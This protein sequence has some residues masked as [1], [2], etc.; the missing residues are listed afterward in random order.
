[1]EVSG[2]VHAPA[3]LPMGKTP[4]PT[5]QEVRS[6]PEAIKGVLEKRKSLAPTVQPREFCT[7]FGA[8]NKC[9]FIYLYMLNMKSQ[10]TT[11]PLIQS[12]F[13]YVSKSLQVFVCQIFLINS[14]LLCH[15]TYFV[16]EENYALRSITDL[17]MTEQRTTKVVSN[18]HKAAF[19]SNTQWIWVCF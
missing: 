9:S 18:W 1:M 15:F 3:A 7:F 2:Q 14:F 16:S 8:L 5:E 11:T 13:Q 19:S 4:V 12:N 10:V 17:M 6:T